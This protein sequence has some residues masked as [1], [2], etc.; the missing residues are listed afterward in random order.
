MRD[1]SQF[2]QDF[3][4]TARLSLENF[5]FVCFVMAS[6]M[7]IVSVVVKSCNLID[8]LMFE[9]KRLRGT[10]FVRRR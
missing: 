8:V 1:C 5:K 9:R 7:V 10:H 4:D 6:N 2:W 3:L